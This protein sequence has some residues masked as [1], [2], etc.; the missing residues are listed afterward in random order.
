MNTLANYAIVALLISIPILLAISRKY[1]TIRL[2]AKQVAF[3]LPTLASLFIGSVYLFSGHPK[4]LFSLSL[5]DWI[6]FIFLLLL[7]WTYGYFFVYGFI[8]SC[9]KSSCRLGALLRVSRTHAVRFGET[10]MSER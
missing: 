8:S 9:I 1:G 2:T 7:F 3:T 4:T 10:E 6:L 5:R